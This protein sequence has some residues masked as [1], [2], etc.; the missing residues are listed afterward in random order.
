MMTTEQKTTQITQ[1]GTASAVPEKIA[2]EYLAAGLSVLP[3]SRRNKHPVLKTWTEFQGRLPT[4]KEVDSWFRASDD[5]VCIVCGKVSGNLEC[6]DFDSHGE[7]F[8]KWA[9]ALPQE[10]FDRLVIERT[11]SGGFHVSYRCADEICGNIKL[12]V[13]MRDG[14]RTTLIE[15]RGEGGLILCAPSRGYALCQGDYEHLPTLTAD[16]R[17][18]L[19]KAAWALNEVAE[20][21]EQQPTQSEHAPSAMQP[22]A[23]DGTPVRPGD[24][25]NARGDLRAL[26]QRH[27]WKPLRTTADGNEHW[28]RRGKKGDG[29]S[30]TLKDNSFYV[31]SSNASPFEPEKSYSPFMVYA[32]LEHGGDCAEAASAL[33]KEGYGKVNECQVDISA[34]TCKGKAMTAKVKKENVG[35][36]GVSVVGDDHGNVGNGVGNVGVSVVGDGKSESEW[37]PIALAP[38]VLPPPPFP[39]EA[40]PGVL[41]EMARAISATCKV[42]VAIPASALL[43]AVGLAIGRSVYFFVKKDLTGRANLYMLVFAARGE[44]KSTVFSPVMAG[45]RPWLREKLKEY[46]TAMSDAAISEAKR[47]NIRQLLAKPL[48]DDEE[49]MERL[50]AEL[51]QTEGQLAALPSNPDIFCNDTTDE[52]LKQRLAQCG[53]T[54]GI[55]SDDSRG[56]LKQIMGMRYSKDGDAHDDTLLDAFDGTKDLNYERAQRSIIPVERPCVGLLLM[57]QTDM[58]PQLYGN[59][60]LSSSGFNS[61]CL[62]CF[63]ESWVGEVVEDGNL[64]RDYDETVIDPMLEL[65]YSNLIYGLMEAAYNRKEVEYVGLTP[66]AK[67][68]WIERFREIERESGIQGIYHNVID[69]A[70]RYPTQGLRIALICAVVNEH[71]EIELEDVQAGFS[72]LSYYI[73]CIERIHAMYSEFQLPADSKRILHHFQRYPNRL[74]Y[75]LRDIYKDM[76]MTS[77]QA[78]SAVI[79]LAKRNYCRIDEKN[80][81]D[82]NPKVFTL[83][84]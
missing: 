4:E 11:P 51:V 75:T 15:T 46:R 34:I 65:R 33:A 50:H 48:Q 81:I 47:N 24:D 27:G 83:A 63:P 28:Q 60:E 55:F 76:S 67:A 25:F 31:F 79:T 61:R 49:R 69:N 73:A 7:L 59:G 64:L 71:K 62:F 17:E 80:R 41:G 38:V 54:A 53:G 23:A 26:L 5:A 13:G 42:P 43:A 12:A 8:P 22:I 52:A 40:M 84:D 36:V 66:Q 10:L 21:E 20:E 6:I 18:T 39:I 37:P 44:R 30:A 58:L 82:V 3:A 19:L 9:E 35:N 29:T 45:F 77:V 78:E 68:F 72:L 16:E 70:I 1:P 57:T 32:L 2:Q 56:M 14:K 74:F